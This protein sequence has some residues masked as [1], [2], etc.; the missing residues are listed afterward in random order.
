MSERLEQ[1]K[2]D[3]DVLLDERARRLRDLEVQSPGERHYTDA[4]LEEIEEQIDDIKMLMEAAAGWRAA[5]KYI[6]RRISE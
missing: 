4:E 1:L 2:R 5:N 3:L 6:G